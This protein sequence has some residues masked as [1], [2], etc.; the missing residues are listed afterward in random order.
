MMAA[1]TAFFEDEV[2]KAQR[3]GVDPLIY[4]GLIAALES[5]AHTLLREP[6]VGEAEI[7]RRSE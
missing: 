6:K 7:E 1:A 3:E 5:V 4:V 2:R